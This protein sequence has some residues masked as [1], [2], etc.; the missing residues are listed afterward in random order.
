MAVYLLWALRNPPSFSAHLTLLEKKAQHLRWGFS[1][2]GTWI[3][4]WKKTG[5]M[6]DSLG[7]V[8]T[9]SRPIH[10][11]N[12]PSLLQCT[13]ANVPPVIWSPQRKSGGNSSLITGNKALVDQQSKKIRGLV[14]IHWT[15]IKTQQK[16]NKSIYIHPYQTTSPLQWATLQR[17][18]KTR[19]LGQ[20]NRC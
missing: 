18:S 11:Y 15:W 5:Y 1:H 10:N 4:A 14:C 9:A 20:I 12:S 8:Y 7:L 6:L 2:A 17:H 19:M 16:K 13:D 3:S